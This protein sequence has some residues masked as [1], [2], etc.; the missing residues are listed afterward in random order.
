M[1]MGYLWVTEYRGCHFRIEYFPGCNPTEVSVSI[2]I[3]GTEDIIEARCPADNVG[4]TMEKLIRRGPEP[5]REYLAK[6]K[7]IA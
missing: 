3:P 2:R 7:G 5:E 4:A 6:A 1:S